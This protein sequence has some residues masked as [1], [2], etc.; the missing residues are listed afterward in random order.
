[1]HIPDLFVPHP[2]LGIT[3]AEPD[4]SLY[5]RDRLLDR[6]DV[7]LALAESEEGVNI[8]AIVRERRLVFRNGL[9]V[10]ALRTQ[11]VGLG[12]MRDRAARRC[13]QGLLA[14][15]FRA[16]KISRRRGA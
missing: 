11:Q 12:D 8:V 13:R 9:R 10:S 7:E 14:Q 4:G 5:E 15:P 3:G 1:M 16:F 2:E 6:A